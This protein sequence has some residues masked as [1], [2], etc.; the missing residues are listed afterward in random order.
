MKKRTKI[1]TFFTT[2]ALTFGMLWLTLGP[3]HF[4]Q[5]YRHYHDHWEH[6]HPYDNQ[7][8]QDVIDPDTNN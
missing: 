4:N 6:H 5:R 8:N 1:I 3:D 2:A 7:D